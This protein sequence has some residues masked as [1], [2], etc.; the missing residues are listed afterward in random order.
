MELAPGRKI[1][2]YTE[3]RDQLLLYRFYYYS[4]ILKLQY[5]DCLAQLNQEFFMSPAWIIQLMDK[6]YADY[7]ELV[8]SKPTTKEMDE[9]FPW[10]KWTPLRKV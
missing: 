7:V 1:R 10:L 5:E 2:T 6:N 8:S 4:H 9:L 3:E